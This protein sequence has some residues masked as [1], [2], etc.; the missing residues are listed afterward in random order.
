MHSPPE[1]RRSPVSPANRSPYVPRTGFEDDA[2][3]QSP[4]GVQ[5]PPYAD[6]Q[7]ESPRRVSFNDPPVTQILSNRT[8][9]DSSSPSNSPVRRRS[10]SGDLEASVP[11]TSSIASPWSVPSVVGTNTQL[12]SY[13]SRAESVAS[14]GGHYPG[15]GNG[16]PLFPS[17]HD[18]SYTPR[19]PPHQNLES[20]HST[21]RD[22]SSLHPNLPTAQPFSDH[23]K[24]PPPPPPA[25]GFALICG[26]CFA[27]NGL[28]PQ[29][30][31]EATRTSLL[32]PVGTC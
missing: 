9:T 15:S 11:R 25:Q 28:L 21:L 18:K 10:S 6:D 7:D 16:P 26:G 17:A 13:W 30:I 19:R 24:A 8:V 29:S 2:A 4:R 14:T 1:A 27:H 23:S 3:T 20:I 5:D 31:W 32:Q 12:P 22:D